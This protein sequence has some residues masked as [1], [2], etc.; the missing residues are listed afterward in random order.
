MTNENFLSDVAPI[1]QLS[2]IQIGYEP[3][4][5]WLRDRWEK[6]VACT[7]VPMKNASLVEKLMAC[8]PKSTSVPTT[9]RTRMA[10]RVLQPL[11]LR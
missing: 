6:H 11:E 2:K 10:H 5:V 3:F 9:Q 8:S 1:L 4:L 7:D